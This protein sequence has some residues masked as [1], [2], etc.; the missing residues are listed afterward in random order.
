MNKSVAEANP[1]L[2]PDWEQVHDHY[3]VTGVPVIFALRTRPLIRVFIDDGGS[4]LGAVFQGGSCADVP[5]RLA[6]VSMQDIHADGARALELSVTSRALFRTFH[7]LLADLTTRVEASEDVSRTVTD[8]LQEWQ[9]LLKV[10]SAL[11]EDRRQGLYGELWLLRR[12]QQSG[13]AN[14]LDAWTGP[15]GASHDFRLLGFDVEI[16]TTRGT[17]RVHHIHGLAQLTPMPGVPLFLLSLRLEAAGQVGES[18]PEAVE[19]IARRM[20]ASE[21]DRFDS[22]M[23]RCGYRE[24]DAHLYLE[25]WRLAERPRIIAVDESCPRLTAEA[26]RSM[27][28]SFV[29]ERIIDVSYEVDVDGLGVADGT[30]DFLAIIPPAE[31]QDE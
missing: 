2:L 16:K 12:L 9:S 14:A 22:L 25:R 21:R 29:P 15:F 17:R 6:A 5:I 10:N 8:V 11:S 1:L 30:E 3:I 4:R 19:S 31:W 18:L 13:T 24:A 7:A 27:P 23:A 20:V 26:I 28:P